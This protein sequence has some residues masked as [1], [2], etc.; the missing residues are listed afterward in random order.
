MNFANKLQSCHLFYPSFSFQSSV[1]QLNPH[2]HPPKKKA[3]GFNLSLIVQKINKF[4]D[5]IENSK[6]NSTIEM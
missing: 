1:F 4:E 6:K 5:W 3:F 2:P